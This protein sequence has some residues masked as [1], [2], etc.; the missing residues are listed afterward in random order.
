MNFSVAS[1][2][3][4]NCVQLSETSS[5]S[6]FQNELN[7]NT[8]DV[9]CVQEVCDRRIDTGGCQGDCQG[10]TG[11]V[12]ELFIADK[13]AYSCI[14]V[15]STALLYS[16][17]LILHKA[18]CVRRNTV[19][20]D[21]ITEHGKRKLKDGDNDKHTVL[22]IFQKKTQ[23]VLVASVH[24]EACQLHLNGNNTSELQNVIHQIRHI[25][26][27]EKKSDA[28]TTLKCHL[29]M[30]SLPIIIAGD[31]NRDPS[32]LT[33]E[34]RRELQGFEY[35]VVPNTTP[36]HYLTRMMSSGR[37]G[38][39]RERFQYILQLLLSWIGYVNTDVERFW[40]ETILDGFMYANCSYTYFQT[41]SG[42]GISDHDCIWCVFTI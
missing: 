42:Q 26:N 15:H 20:Y 24:L 37:G 3:V 29:K 30:H 41:L 13:N 25:L 6:K 28:D 17:E 22:A 18:Y 34:L 39:L 40:S 23:F 36:T 32:Q 1:F 9:V 2:N 8:F 31:F 11:R 19:E 5:S 4:E 27:V 10:N 35:K 16:S 7:V 38:L 33:L 21:D 12:K 14:R